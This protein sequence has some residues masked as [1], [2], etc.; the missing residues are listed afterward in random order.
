MEK[1]EKNLYTIFKNDEL[2]TLKVIFNGCQQLESIKMLCGESY[3][4]ESELLEVV[5]YSSKNFYDIISK[6]IIYPI[7]LICDPNYFL[8]NWDRFL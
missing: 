4:N 2:E 5:K 1:N 8:K 7:C 3:L 6:Y